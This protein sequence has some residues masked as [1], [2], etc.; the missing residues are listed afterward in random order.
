VAGDAA[1][2]DTGFTVAIVTGIVYLFGST[3]K[4]TGT[5]SAGVGAPASLG[6]VEKARTRWRERRLVFKEGCCM[7]VAASLDSRNMASREGE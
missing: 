2:G 7:N 4:S 5:A 1:G 3:A 6:V